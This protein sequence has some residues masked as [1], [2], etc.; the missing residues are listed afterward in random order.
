MKAIVIE[1]FGSKDVLKVREMPKPSPLEN[2]V[3]IHVAYAGVNPVDWKIREGYLKNLI[4]HVFPLILGWDVSGIVVH[5]GMK[6]QNLKLGDEVFSYI[7]K[8][9][10]QWGAYA[11]YV[12]FDAKDV[13]KKPKCVSLAEAA[14]LPLV[15]LTAWQAL[16]A[17][18]KIKKGEIVLIQGASGG[19]GI[20]GVQ[21]AK[22]A[23]AT[24]IATASAPKHEYVKEMHAD[25]VLDYKENIQ[26]QVREF[27][28]EG[29]DVVFDCYGSDAFQEGL[30]CLKKGGRIVSIMEQLDQ[31]EAERL[32]IQAKYVFVTPNGS[33]LTEIK[34]LIEEKRIVPPHIEEIPLKD[35]AVAQERLRQ[36]QVFGKLVLKI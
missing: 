5:V 4:P 22:H 26:E 8:P 24:V 29:V 14:A 27:A 21:F 6:V 35:A 16:F 31:S 28:P 33:D 3:L 32:G 20:M 17:F 30:T 9:I 13:V 34:K 25:I 18:G 11:E 15:S 7:R 23:G 1:E 19:V 2:E 36:G 10:V 12:T